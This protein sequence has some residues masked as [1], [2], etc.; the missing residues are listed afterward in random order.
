MK[1]EKN[2]V[3]DTETMFDGDC[4]DPE[5]FNDIYQNDISLARP[6]AHKLAVEDKY[7]F[8]LMKL[9]S[10]LSVVDLKERFNIA[11]STVNNIF[12]QKHSESYS[13][14]KSHT[15]LKCLLGV[16]PKSGIL[17][18]SQLY[19]GSVSDKQMYSSE[20]WFPRYPRLKIN[21]C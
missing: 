17:S 21:G 11:E 14:Y 8:V 16:D 20:K 1:Q 10:F 12:L 3:I 19:E 5:D 6:T 2:T 13:T 4:D 7:L 18:I 9:R 15:T